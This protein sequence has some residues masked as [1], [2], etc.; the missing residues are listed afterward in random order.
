ML[1]GKEI[2]KITLPISPKL[3]PKVTALQKA[4]RT[5][6]PFSR[7]GVYEKNINSRMN[8]SVEDDLASV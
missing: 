5:L 6:E 7:Q 3:E 1:K 2:Y 8:Q 4:L